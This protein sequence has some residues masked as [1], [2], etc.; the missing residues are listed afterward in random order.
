MKTEDIE[1]KEAEQLGAVTPKKTV[2]ELERE[3]KELKAEAA[4][5][6]RKK[7]EAKEKEKADKESFKELSYE[8]LNK[9]LELFVKKQ[10]LM[11]QDIEAAF[12]DYAP[13]LDLKE[14]AYG[15]KVRKQ[16][17]H[18]VT[19]PDGSASITIGFNTDI[20]YDGTENMGIDKIKSFLTSIDGNNDTVK[21]LVKTVNI[22]LKPS[23]KTG[24]LNPSSIIQLNAMRGDW[25]SKDFNDGL[26]IIINAQGVARSSQYVEGWQIVDMGNDRTKKVKFRFTVS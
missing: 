1:V 19:L 7:K 9:H 5:E 12:K 26:D 23:K 13:L 22:L 17:S 18:T 24:Q 25:N 11:E 10:T 4:A 3:L 16:Y 20:I 15:E 8:F 6:K 14:A 21:N 2:A